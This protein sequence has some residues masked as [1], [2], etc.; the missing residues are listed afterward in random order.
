MSNS[1]SSSFSR[2]K[3]S[4]SSYKTYDEYQTHRQEKLDQVSSDI[5]A[6]NEKDVQDLQDTLRDLMCQLSAA[7]EKLTLD[8]RDFLR[9]KESLNTELK[10]VQINADVRYSNARIEY[11]DNVEQL[12][13]A[14]HLSLQEYIRSLP[15]I[16]EPS[17]SIDILYNKSNSTSPKNSRFSTTKKS[18]TTII[19]DELD[20]N[21]AQLYHDRILV[22]EDQRKELMHQIKEDERNNQGKLE[23][24]SLMIDN[25]E[26]IYEQEINKLQLTMK[27]KEE[28]Y[29]QQLLK[30]YADLQRAIDR[31]IEATE[32][33]QQKVGALQAQI[34]KVENDTR[35]KLIE[36]IHKAEKLKAS[37]KHINIQKSKQLEYDQRI[38]AQTKELNE[39]SLR[40][41]QQMFTM[42]RE[43]QKAKAE[44]QMLRRE[45]CQQIGP[46]KVQSLFP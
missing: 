34:D 2:S 21:D 38:S 45:L 40:L 27:T 35:Q 11:I 28:Q 44:S 8:E 33:R 19:N 6:K 7:R 46:R 14:Y 16:S 17:K 43:L 3:G 12:N 30:L 22:L 4:Q 23:E 39:E 10:Q 20:E 31:R 32:R 18:S 41:Q 24:I 15:N 29:E 36:S 42:E 9:K 13:Q 26:T 1:F 5:Q 25:Q 37:L